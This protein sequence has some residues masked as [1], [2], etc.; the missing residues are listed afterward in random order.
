MS[1]VSSGQIIA[2]TGQAE[3]GSWVSGT[4]TAASATSMMAIAMDGWNVSPSSTSTSLSSS[5]PTSSI[6]QPYVLSTGARVGI[7]VGIAVGIIGILSLI[8]FLYRKRR[9]THPESYTTTKSEM[10]A[11][12]QRPPHEMNTRATAYEM[13]QHPPE[14]ESG[15]TLKS[16]HLYR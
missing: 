13:Y 4:T 6:S 9:K 15:Q 7:G 5:T 3:N 2:Y 11:E 16:K 8:F 14:L 12:G 10:S 1:P